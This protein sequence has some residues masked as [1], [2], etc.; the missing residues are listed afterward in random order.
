M[1]LLTI[2]ITD[3]ISRP[4]RNIEIGKSRLILNKCIDYDYYYYF[5][6]IVKHI[7]TRNKTHL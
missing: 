5:I 2:Y 1:I 6:F 3:T 4:I 7:I